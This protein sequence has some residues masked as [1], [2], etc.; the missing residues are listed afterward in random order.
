MAVRV[1]PYQRIVGFYWPDASPYITVPFTYYNDVTWTDELGDGPEATWTPDLAIGY[2]YM[3]ALTRGFRT[4]SLYTL[5]GIPVDQ[6]ITPDPWSYIVQVTA[7]GAHYAN[8]ADLVQEMGGAA[9]T[10]GP[11]FGTEYAKIDLAVSVQVM[12]TPYES[13][14]LT[15][16]TNIDTDRLALTFTG[17]GTPDPTLSNTTLLSEFTFDFS[18]LTV[19]NGGDTYSAVGMHIAFPTAYAYF[20]NDAREAIFSVVLKKDEVTA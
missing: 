5:S 16:Y 18:G 13:G 3:T 1:G 17:V 7:V 4:S 8:R 11:L 9:L 6:G 10:D 14:T 19:T 15:K 12:W 20:P 2:E